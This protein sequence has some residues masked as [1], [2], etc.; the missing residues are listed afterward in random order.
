MEGYRAVSGGAAAV[1][2]LQQAETLLHEEMAAVAGRDAFLH[3][4]AGTRP[5]KGKAPEVLGW[6]LGHKA[7]VVA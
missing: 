1:V 4:I 2:L 7:S 5:P 3:P 6:S